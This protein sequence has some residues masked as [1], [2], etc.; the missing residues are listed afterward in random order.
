MG[1]Y[2]FLYKLHCFIV[3]YVIMCEFFNRWSPTPAI[4]PRCAVVCSENAAVGTELKRMK[5]GIRTQG[6]F[7]CA[8]LL[9]QDLTPLLA[10]LYDTGKPRDM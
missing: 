10:N 9:C 3:L 6:L 5:F 4:W 2:L 1:L 7:V 8:S